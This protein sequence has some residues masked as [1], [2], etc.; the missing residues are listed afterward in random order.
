MKYCRLMSHK[1]FVENTQLACCSSKATTD[2][3]YMMGV[4]V[5]EQTLFTMTGSG[6]AVICGLLPRDEAEFTRITK[7]GMWG[8]RLQGQFLAIVSTP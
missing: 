7:S 4:G 5:R 2:D 6:Q 1:V 3:R 8:E